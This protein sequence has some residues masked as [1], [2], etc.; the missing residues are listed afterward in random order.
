MERGFTL[1]WDDMKVFLAIANAG[2][3][4]KAALAL[5]IHHT[6]CARRINALETDLGIKLFD[7]LPGGYALTQGGQDLLL[8]AEQIQ[9]GFNT[10]ARDIQGKDLRIA[11]DLCLTLPNGFATHLLM[12][13]IHEFMN[14]YPDIHLELNM[15]YARRDLVS[16][17]ADVAIRHV[18]NPPDSLTGKRVARIYKTAYASEEYLASHDLKINPS[19][20][21]WLGWGNK[22]E[23]L[24]CTEKD[25]YPD[26]PV[27]GKLYSDVL[28]ASAVQAHMGIATLPCFIGDNS[29]G[30]VRIPGAQIH[31][32]D[33][34]W[35]L[36]HKDMAKNSR[37]RVLIEFLVKAFA[38]HKNK[39]EGVLQ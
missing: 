13:D 1:N 28:Q 23:Q 8:S 22:N 34:I 36:A 12:P 15:S 33:W 38:R 14:L 4:K 25:K 21:H 10:I 35:V 6:S 27:R 16:R 19:G 5:K 3:L 39:I 37:V 2:G 29:P 7:R 24:K 26:V 11:G 17:E 18:T 32:G 31:A 20:C 30:M 9:Q